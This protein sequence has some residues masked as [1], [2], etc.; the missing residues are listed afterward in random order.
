[1]PALQ[2][3]GRLVSCHILGVP[4][5]VNE[6]FLALIKELVCSGLVL[7]ITFPKDHIKAYLSNYGSLKSLR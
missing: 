1:M 2:D 7:F 3:S 5:P 4:S 6:Y